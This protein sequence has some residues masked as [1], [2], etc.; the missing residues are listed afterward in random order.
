MTN[1][2]ETLV[3]SL[4]LCKKI[5]MGCFSDSALVFASDYTQENPSWTVIPRVQLGSMD[6]A[7]WFNAPTLEEIFAEIDAIGRCWPSAQYRENTWR[8]ECLYLPGYWEYD[9]SPCMYDAECN[10]NAATAALKL[11]IKIKEQQHAYLT[12]GRP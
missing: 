1:L 3:P 10:R 12:I 7:E 5:P 6:Y 4:E 2:L 11:W 8:V 9:R